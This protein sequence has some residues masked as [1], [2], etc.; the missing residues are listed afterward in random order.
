MGHGLTALLIGAKS[1][2]LT[3]VT[4]SSAYDSRLVE[5]GGTLANL[6]AALVFWLVLRRAR[7]SSV[8]MRYFLLIDCAYNLFTGT[9][10]FFFSGV[11]NFGDWAALGQ[12]LQEQSPN[13]RG[14]AGM[15]ARTNF[16]SL[17]NPPAFS[18]SASSLYG[19]GGA[20]SLAVGVIITP[21]VQSVALL[22][23]FARAEGSQSD[24]HNPI[25]TNLPSTT[26]AT[27]TARSGRLIM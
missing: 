12:N 24:S 9:G 4:W 18:K 25:G 23:C 8:P 14:P 21:S 10:Y 26:D 6:A 16:Q 27:A 2:V 3:T 1:G 17:R 11:T 20:G 22:H 13:L 15:S 7:V 19:R 5:A